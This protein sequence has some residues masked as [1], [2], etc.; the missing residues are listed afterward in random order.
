MVGNRNDLYVDMKI[1][2]KNALN[3]FKYLRGHGIE[4]GLALRRIGPFSEGRFHYRDCLAVGGELAVSADGRLG[5]CHNAI[6]GGINFS[7]GNLIDSSFNFETSRIFS[8]WHARMPLNMKACREC[9]FIALCG[10]G[11]PYNAYLHKGSIW[12]ID[13]QQCGYMLEFVNWLLEDVWERY[14]S[15]VPKLH[16]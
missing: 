2:A 13:P 11:C 14:S 1:A 7:G 9:S 16:Y 12:D 6:S 5:P 3:A 10:G 8:E 4:E 15:S